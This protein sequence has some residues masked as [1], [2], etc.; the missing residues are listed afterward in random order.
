MA[1]LH[2]PLNQIEERHLEAFIAAG[3]VESSSIDLRK[4]DG[5]APKEVAREDA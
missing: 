2:I 3:A 1:L 5:V 4:D